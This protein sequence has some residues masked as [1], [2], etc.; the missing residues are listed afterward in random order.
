LGNAITQ[1]LTLTSCGIFEQ[2]TEASTKAV[3][4]VRHRAGI[5]TVKR[6]QFVI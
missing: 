1:K 4:Q 6:Y 2:M 3:A 5:A